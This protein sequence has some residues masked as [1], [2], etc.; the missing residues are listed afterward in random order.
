[1]EHALRQRAPDLPGA[2]QRPLRPAR[3]VAKP[4]AADRADLDY[5]FEKRVTKATGGTGCADVWK[6]RLFRLGVQ[7]DRRATSPGAYAQL[8]GYMNALENPPLLVVSDTKL[9]RIYPNFPNQKTVPIDIP[10][11]QI[12]RRRQPRH[13]APRLHRPDVL[14]GQGHAPRAVT[15]VAAEKFGAI[16]AA[17]Q[18]R[19]EDP[20]ASP[21]SSSSSSSASSPR[22]SA[23]CRRGSSAS[24]SPS[25]RKLRPSSSQAITDLLSQ[26]ATGGYFGARRSRTS[27]AASSARSRHAARARRNWPP[28]PRPPSSNWSK[29]E[30][31]IFGTLFER[32]LDPASRA[33]LGA[34]YTGRADIER[35]VEPVVMT[36][37]RRRWD[38]V[39]AEADAARRP[40][41]T[42]LP[43]GER[44]NDA[45]GR[46]RRA[47]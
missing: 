16:A 20:H 6:T 1:M 39:R 31:A 30:P 8:L 43:R 29:V 12:D 46:L 14:P 4:S 24:C 22:T 9:I 25:A 2:L 23:S 28:W 11:S 40:L 10:L 3:P 15:K 35:V 36:P 7:G 19:G 18:A 17:L 38:E 13:P 42:A 21:T 26:M 27:T 5:T 33:K 37:L 45:P 34:H 47:N 32:S 44:R 41:A